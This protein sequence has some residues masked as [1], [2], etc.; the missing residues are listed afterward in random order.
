MA[1]EDGAEL[2]AARRMA[3]MRS[4]LAAAKLL[5]AA[6]AVWLDHGRDTSIINNS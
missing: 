5:T 1:A 4:D 6:A 3:A 2:V